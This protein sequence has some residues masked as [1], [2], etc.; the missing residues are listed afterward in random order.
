MI[1]LGSLETIDG[2][3][4]LAKEVD[5]FKRKHP[6]PDSIYIYKAMKALKLWYKTNELMPK[7]EYQKIIILKYDD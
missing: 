4:A 2:T 1:F 3:C 7:W 6:N 5:S